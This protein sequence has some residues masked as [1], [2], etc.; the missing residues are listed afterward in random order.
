MA[1][2][3]IVVSRPG[4]IDP[5]SGATFA[6]RADAI[7]AA[8]AWLASRAP[9]RGVYMLLERTWADGSREALWHVAAT[10]RGDAWETRT[11]GRPGAPSLDGRLRG[12]LAVLARHAD[13]AAAGGFMSMASL[14]AA[15]VARADADALAALGLVTVEGRTLTV[16]DGFARVTPAGRAALALAAAAS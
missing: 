14:A 5:A 8:G 4:Y 15:R 7:A 11:D 13:F 16:P 10:A 6:R 1:Y 12:V 2:R 9:A 3:L